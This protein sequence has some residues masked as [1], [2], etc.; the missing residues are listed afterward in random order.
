[1]AAAI[2]GVTVRSGV[3]LTA[4]LVAYLRALRG[5]LDASVPL[6]VTSGVRSAAAQ[7]SA[8]LKKLD[9]GG[10]QELYD[11]YQSDAT[12][13]RLLDSGRDAATW[14]KIIQDETSK[15]VRLSRHLGGGSF[16]LHTSTLSAD[17]LGKM[18][19]AVVATGGRYLYEDA[20]PHL[21][22]DVPA[23]FAVGSAV[24]VAEMKAKT[25]LTLVGRSAGSAVRSPWAWV[26]VGGAAVALAVVVVRR[27]KRVS[28]VAPGVTP[29]DTRGAS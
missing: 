9:A 24:E 1:M 15:G 29:P 14:A 11:V 4:G 26:F 16:D 27:R 2:S 13:K 10:A 22:V 7:A 21:H 19:A 20:P 6:T 25:A 5:S 18:K 3:I 28:S 12:V 17:Q 8:M 23:K